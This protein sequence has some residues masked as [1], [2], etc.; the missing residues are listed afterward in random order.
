M[1]NY[2]TYKKFVNAKIPVYGIKEDSLMIDDSIL[3]TKC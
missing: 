1:K 2:N 3:N